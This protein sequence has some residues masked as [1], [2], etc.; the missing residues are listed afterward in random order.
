[1][2][3]TPLVKK[4]GIKPGQTMVLLHPPN[5]YLET[6]GPL[7]EGVS[8]DG[9]QADGYDVVHLFVR[10]LEELRR[11]LPGALAA[12]KP[13]VLFWISYPKQT[14]GMQTNINRDTLWATMRGTGWRP[15]TQV[16]VDNV[17]SAL[18]FRPEEDV[19]RS[20]RAKGG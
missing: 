13:G 20:K 11:E 3:G 12:G 18:R 5:G 7:P 19:A 17:W 16:A 9:E 1:M 6:L 2:A 15:V 8:V 10:D 14:G 4:L